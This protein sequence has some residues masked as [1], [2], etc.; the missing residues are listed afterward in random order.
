[1]TAVERVSYYNS[2]LF[3]WP[4]DPTKLGFPALIDGNSHPFRMDRDGKNK[5]DLTQGLQGVR[6]RLQRLAGR[7]AHRLPQE[8]PGLPRRRRRL[9]RQARQ[10]R[11]AVQLRARSGRRTGPWLL[12]LAG[13]HYD[14]HPHVVR[15][16]GT[17]L[18]KLADRDGYRGVIEFLDVP[19][20]H[21]G[22]SDVPVWSADGKSVFYTAKVGRN[23]ELFRVD[24]RRQGE[25]LT[26]DAGRL[27]ALPPAARRRTASGWSTARSA[28]ASGSCT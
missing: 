12:F 23:V 15:A 28:T 21:G 4:G 19:D 26:D 11:P 1:M 27:A 5:R 17:G 14:C 7:Q 22:S 3:F 10:D 18:K 8:L 6:L 9:E 24:A 2:G 25:Q 13:E 20:F 16:D